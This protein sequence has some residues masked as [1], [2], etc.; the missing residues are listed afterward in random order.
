[1]TTSMDIPFD[2]GPNSDPIK[3]AIPFIHCNMGGEMVYILEQ[4]LYSQKI[5]K[6]KIERVIDD[7]IRQL[8]NPKVFRELLRPGPLPS[9]TYMRGIF[10]TI[11]NTSI[12]KLSEASM[13]KMYELMVMGFK[14]QVISLTHPKDL[15]SVTLNHVESNRLLTQPGSQARLMIDNVQVQLEQMM[16]R[17]TTAQFH[18]TRWYLCKFFQ[19]RRTK[20]S[21]FLREGLQTDR[22]YFPLQV[23]GPM[24][25]DELVEM[26]GVARYYDHGSAPRTEAF[27]HPIA[28]LL[29]SQRKGDH[30]DYQTREIKLG[31]N[32]YISQTDE[33]RREALQAVGRPERAPQGAALPSPDTPPLPSAPEP[34]PAAA[35]APTAPVEQPQQE[36]PHSPPAGAAAAAG[37]DGGFPAPSTGPSTEEDSPPPPRPGVERRGPGDAHAVAKTRDHDHATD[38]QY[39]G[40]LLGRA[41][42]AD[43]D[44]DGGRG[45]RFNPFGDGAAAAAGGGGEV[46]EIQRMTR[47]QFL[48][49]NAE[50]VSMMDELEILDKVY[51]DASR[52]DSGSSLLDLL[53]EEGL[54]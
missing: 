14:F 17:M 51:N 7:I 46:I 2:G 12:M 20:V 41:P 3:L 29:T 33:Q 24:P 26:P 16:R 19:D 49:I 48:K 28:R 8:Y 15:I 31:T 5:R 18:T 40:S 47:D 36:E 27:V 44:A 32:V 30:F 25:N 53:R 35:S 22:G 43:A 54:A 4:R 11:A 1:M 9:N 45:F 52:R 50:L 23:G 38:T 13:E 42:Q 37:Q 34:P 6:D 21:L 10:H 39:L